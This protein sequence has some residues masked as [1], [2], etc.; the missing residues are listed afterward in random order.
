M[1]PLPKE[2]A[3]T[4]VVA[5][6]ELVKCPTIDWADYEE[7]DPKVQALSDI[8]KNVLSALIILMYQSKECFGRLSKINHSDIR[9][10]SFSKYLRDGD[11]T[12][13]FNKLLK[14]KIVI[15][16]KEEKEQF[17]TVPRFFRRVAA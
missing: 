6:Y 2:R 3:M 5:S 12:R 11:I 15:A 9:Q 13:S 17:F 10:F 16:V 8:G 1:A 14:N 4:N 7:N